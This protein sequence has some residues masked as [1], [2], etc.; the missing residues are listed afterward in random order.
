MIGVISELGGGETLLALFWLA[1]AGCIW[2]LTELLKNK[3]LPWCMTITFWVYMVHLNMERCINK[4]LGILLC[5]YAFVGVLIN[6]ILGVILTYLLAVFFAYLLKKYCNRAW[7]IIN[8]Y[9]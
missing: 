3:K 9:R 6:I 8:G 2:I 7:K 4:I 1:G 5:R